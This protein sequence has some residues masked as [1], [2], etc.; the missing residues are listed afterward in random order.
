MSKIEGNVPGDEPTLPPEEGVRGWMCV[1][2]SFMALFA[3]FGFLN[4]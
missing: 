3:T 2:G 1:V 4:A